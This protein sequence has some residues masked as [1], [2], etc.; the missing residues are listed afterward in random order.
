MPSD[1]APK[2]A[3]GLLACML[4]MMCAGALTG[5]RWGHR[6]SRRKGPKK[7]N[8][9]CRARRARPS[10]LAARFSPDVERQR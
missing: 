9:G 10:A 6:E 1:A 5:A 7:I 3:Q 8:Q 2:S 4:V